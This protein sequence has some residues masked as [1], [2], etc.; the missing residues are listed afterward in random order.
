M[1]ALEREVHV[2]RRLWRGSLS[3]AFIQPVLF[4]AAIGLGL[5]GLVEQNTGEV[6]GVKYLAFIAPGL[7][8]ASTMLV[9]AS[10]GLW[11]LMGRLKWM[12]SYKAMITTPITP[13]DA[14]QGWLVWIGVRSA[15]AASAFLAA[16]TLLG[17]VLSPWAVLAV[18]AAVLN[19]AAFAAP[20]GAFNATQDT[21]FR[22][23]V[24]MRLGIMPLFLFSG[25]FF[26]VEQLPDGLQPVVWLSPL[27]HGA[28]L[29]R[30][31]TTGHIDAGQAVVHV[32]VLVALVLLGAR[33]GARTF[34][35]RLTP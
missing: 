27:F 24:I 23:P 3:F 22:F 15:L 1:R 12:G 11:P 2:F 13:A 21:D 34:T 25:T 30:G 4:L 9:G 33:W 20:I 31:A 8:A 10:E 7:L 5:G 17:G 29:C 14:F 18:P 6:D 32:A 19:A 28:E 16:A 35:R 26:P